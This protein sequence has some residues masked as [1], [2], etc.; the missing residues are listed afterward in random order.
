MLLNL[1][2][3][4]ADHCQR[5]RRMNRI[6]NSQRQPRISSETSINSLLAELTDRGSL[7]YD[8]RI[9]EMSG[10]DYIF[11]PDAVCR[12]LSGLRHLQKF[13][14][15]VRTILS[16]GPSRTVLISYWH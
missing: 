14:S 15:D 8:L 1:G 13:F 11:A 12:Q 16:T 9:A 5:K 6:A 7:W 4:R 10:Y 3:D 2:M